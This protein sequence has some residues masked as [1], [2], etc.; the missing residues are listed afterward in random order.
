MRCIDLVQRCLCLRFSAWWTAKAVISL[1]I[2]LTHVN[3]EVNLIL[4]NKNIKEFSATYAWYDNFLLKM[5]Y[6]FHLKVSLSSVCPVEET[7]I[8]Q[9]FSPMEKDADG[10]FGQSYLFIFHF[11]FFIYLIY[12]PLLLE[13]LWRSSPVLFFHWKTSK[14]TMS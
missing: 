11:Y 13:L 12:H 5:I 4:K 6:C 7:E 8:L 1:N 9:M 14:L 10:R 3:L 2:V